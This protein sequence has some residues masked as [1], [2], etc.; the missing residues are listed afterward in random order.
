MKLYHG[1]NGKAAGK[2]MRN[3]FLGSQLSEMTDGFT[4][5]ADGVVFMTDSIS[6]AKCYGEAIFA[7][8]IDNP[9]FFQDCPTSNAKEF[10]ADV[11]TVNNCL[12]TRV[13]GMFHGWTNK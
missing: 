5:S 9:T 1:T 2:I 12:V 13:G 10:Y 7:I 11:A 8:E 4:V 6:E 3:G